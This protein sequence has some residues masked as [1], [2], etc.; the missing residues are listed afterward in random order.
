MARADAVAGILSLIV[1]VTAVAVK[2][3]GS[4]VAIYHQ[5]G[6]R[7]CAN[8]GI[9]VI[10]RP[11][12]SDFRQR[13]LQSRRSR[14]MACNTASD[15]YTRIMTFSTPE[16]HAD[17]IGSIIGKNEHVEVLTSAKCRKFSNQLQ[18]RRIMI[19]LRIRPRSKRGAA[20]PAVN[21]NAAPR[22]GGKRQAGTLFPWN[23]AAFFRRD[24]RSGG[25]AGADGSIHRSRAP[26][27]KQGLQ[28]NP[29]AS[30][31]SLAQLRH[32]TTPICSVRADGRFQY[33]PPHVGPRQLPMPARQ[34]LPGSGQPGG[35]R[36]HMTCRP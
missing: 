18:R 5:R 32:Y 22:A 24:D 27:R 2:P 14:P 17:I 19:S 33:L 26:T 31:D 34:P 13:P 12:T 8:R 25:T 6:V 1:R 3:V 16:G 11:L 10:S 7:G 15:R 35:R 4:R 36:H 30:L 20:T 28:W 9:G 23:Q 21:G 29:K